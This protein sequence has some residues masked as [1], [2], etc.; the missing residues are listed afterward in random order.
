MLTWGS[1]YVREN[2][3]RHFKEAEGQKAS[4]CFLRGKHSTKPINKKITLVLV[5]MPWL[6]PVFSH[7]CLQS[8]LHFLLSTSP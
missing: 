7:I 8:C 2:I 6:G 3:C 4:W 1:Y 5:G